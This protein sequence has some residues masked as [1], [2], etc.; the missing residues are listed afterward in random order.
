M[1]GSLL[2]VALVALALAPVAAAQTAQTQVNV[3]ILDLPSEPVQVD[4]GSST[5]VTFTVELQAENFA[6]T[7]EGTLPVALNLGSGPGASHGFALD[8]TQL[9]FTASPGTYSSTNAYN[10]TMEADLS[11]GAGADADDH[12]HQ[13]T[14]DAVFQP[15]GVQNCD[16]PGGFPSASA[17]GTVTV[18]VSGT[19][20]NTTG[21]GGNGG[22][23]G[24]GTDGGTNTGEGGGGGIPGPGAAAAVALAAG[25]RAVRR[26]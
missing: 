1:R 3:R 20:G 21:P 24:G 6:C 22:N 16:S 19:G 15:D 4:A 26:D 7:G 14:I 8:P 17:S 11:Y 23:G 12:T 13:Q 2:V 25:A 18:E 9:N 5:T 10:S